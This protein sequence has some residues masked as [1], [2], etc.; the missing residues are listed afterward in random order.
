MAAPTKLPEVSGMTVVVTTAIIFAV[1]AIVLYLAQ[2]FFPKNI[3]LGTHSLSYFWALYMSMGKLALLTAFILPFVSKY[4]IMR[5][6]IFSPTEWMALYFVVNFV[7]I[8]L[9]TRFS[10]QFGL[11]VTSWVV[12]AA[13]AVVLDVA[14][15]MVMMAYGSML[16]K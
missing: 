3:V 9:I 15:G 12:V 11:G 4:E 2:M 10:E 6:K 14:Q 16:K 13:L 7:G 5:N 8:W 1:N